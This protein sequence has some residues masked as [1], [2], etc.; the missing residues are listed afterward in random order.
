MDI[1]KPKTWTARQG[2]LDHWA[3]LDREGQHEEDRSIKVVELEPM[4]DLL[5]GAF[6]QKAMPDDELDAAISAMLQTHEK[7][8]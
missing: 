6:D 7:H 4:I 1:I 5:Q 2:I 8:V 3:F